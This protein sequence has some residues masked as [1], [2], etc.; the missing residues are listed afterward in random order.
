MSRIMDRGKR[1]VLYN[2]LPEKTFDFE[3]V[4]SIARVSSIQGE[5]RTELNAAVLI[6]RIADEASAWHEDFRP[7]LRDD[8][9]RQP[10]RFILLNPKSVKSELY[11]KV[12]WCQNRG[13][14]R[15]F[16]FSHD[17]YIPTE[18][19]VCKG[20]LI[21]LR[22][23]KIHRCGALKP[24]LPRPCRICHTTKHMSLDARGE[25]ISSFRWICRNCNTPQNLF[26]G[27]CTDCQ[28]P[29]TNLQEMRIEVHRASRTYYPHATVLLNIPHRR[30]DGFF[31]LQEWPAI[32]AAKF[33][34][35]PEVA[36]KK[37]SD[38]GNNFVNQRNNQGSGLS[39]KDLEDLLQRQMKGE[40]TAEDFVKEMQRLHE[41]SKNEQEA[42]SPN[43]I[44][45]GLLKL[46][47]VPWIIWKNS[48]QEMMEAVMPLE[49]GHPKED[50]NERSAQFA[51]LM[52][53]SRIALVA[54][55]PIITATYG[56][57]RAEYEPNL[58]RL[59]PFP[60]HAEHGGRYPIF[61]DEVQADAL[62]ISL[63]PDRVISWLEQNGCLPHIPSG[64]DQ[65]LAR[66]AYFVQL[67]NE[68][69]LRTTITK[70]YR[71]A[72]MVF[73]LLHTL[74]HLAIRQAALLC[75]LERT[76]LSEYLLPRALT[77]AIYCNHRFGATIGALTALF[78]QSMPE[79]LNAIRE[80][81]RC[82]Y[83]PVCIEKSGNCHACTHL[84]E[85][86]C[87]F[88]NLNL[89]RAFLFGGNDLELGQIAVGYFDT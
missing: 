61:V 71:E 47:G 13:C 54:D 38:F 41:K 37:L 72:R 19:P 21:Q 14:S 11:P 55:Y 78:E 42:N 87:R 64:S 68:V 32:A 63:N 27:N 26:A 9:L 65:N 86:S 40:L 4:A 56:Y 57:S 46:T 16:D 12:F 35:L 74:S 59:N 25:R 18:C 58:C 44:V 39:N 33:L 10:N 66:R 34:C 77:F 73:G 5:P 76:S 22:F 29:D 83:D 49:T 62:L 23:V 31:G 75:G 60:A 3:G 7:A 51:S 85:T 1:Q 8:V 82:V 88:F 80:T 20:R 52:G 28:W 53:L 81:R 69:P 79:W 48:G 50:L 70:D 43:G 84:A 2:F 6:A 45:Q 89:S 36:E 67:L 15:V 24:L 30:F 17:D